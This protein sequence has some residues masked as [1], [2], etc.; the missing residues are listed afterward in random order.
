MDCHFRCSSYLRDG[1]LQEETRNRGRTKYVRGGEFAVQNSHSTVPSS[2]AAVP[3]RGHAGKGSVTRRCELAKRRQS[4]RGEVEACT[5]N[6]ARSRVPFIRAC[7]LASRLAIPRL[8]LPPAIHNLGTFPVPSRVVFLASVSRLS[9]YPGGAGS[10][11]V[12]WAQ[13]CHLGTSLFGAIVRSRRHPR[14]TLVGF[15]TLQGHTL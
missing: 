2:R 9:Y 5:E 3:I 6:L 8:L 12:A 4:E 7:V 13:G 10:V 14:L 1:S 15:Q 11:R